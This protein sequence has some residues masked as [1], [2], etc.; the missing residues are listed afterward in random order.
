M[1]I[2]N[3]QAILLTR[4]FA[5]DA[6]VKPSER[7]KRIRDAKQWDQSEVARAV[8]KGS[9]LFRSTSNVCK[10]EKGGAD[11]ASIEILEVLAD[12]LEVPREAVTTSAH[13]GE[14]D[15]LSKA[16]DFVTRH[17]LEFFAA[18]A[19]KKVTPTDADSLRTGM[20]TEILGV[21]ATPLARNWLTGSSR[22]CDSSQA[23]SRF[24]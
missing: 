3:F 6:P 13:D 8:E 23:T 20:M 16:V 10:L 15:P 24:T 2:S 7:I 4:R 22:P 17:S 14:I 19:K 5:P 1:G 9:G 21:T 12:A 18:K 11:R